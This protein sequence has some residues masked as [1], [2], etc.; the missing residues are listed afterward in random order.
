MPEK[1]LYRKRFI[2]METV[3]LKDDKILLWQDD[4]I[5]TKWNSLKPRRDIGSGLSAYYLKDGIKVSKIFDP[6]GNF[7]H[8][9]C[10]MIH[11]VTM[12][13]SIIFEDL[14]IDV[15][16][17]KDGSILVLDADEAADALRQ[18]MISSELLCQALTSMNLL[19]T[20]LYKG[21]FEQYSKIIETLSA[22]NPTDQ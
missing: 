13:N 19:L 5:V 16:V 21:Q 10:D 14:L 3:A 17:K 1:L 12:E 22:Q 20:S 11:P 8:W 7:V 6:N 2:P 15:V 9:Y 4:L 18:G